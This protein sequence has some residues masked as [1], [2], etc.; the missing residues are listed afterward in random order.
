M[1]AAVAEARAIPA[2][3][4]T[5]CAARKSPV[6]AIVDAAFLPMVVICV[7]IGAVGSV[8]GMGEIGLS[9]VGGVGSSGAGG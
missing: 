2:T 9:G 6:R 3:M 4:G 8:G 1:A 7:G 5:Q